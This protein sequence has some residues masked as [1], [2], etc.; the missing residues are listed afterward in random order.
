[1]Y[2]LEIFSYNVTSHFF[3]RDCKRWLEKSAFFWNQHDENTSRSFRLIA[4]RNVLT[5]SES[6]RLEHFVHCIMSTISRQVLKQSANNGLSI[7][8]GTMEVRSVLLYCLWLEICLWNMSIGIKY[9]LSWHTLCALIFSWWR[10]HWAT[11]NMMTD[12]VLIYVPLCW[13]QSLFQDRGIRGGTCTGGGIIDSSHT[14]Q[15]KKI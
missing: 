10:R 3:P 6:D 13:W 15:W 4:T 11:K 7:G 14:D 9:C 1:M 2:W 12:K 5:L 8:I